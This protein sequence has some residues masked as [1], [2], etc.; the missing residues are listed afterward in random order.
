MAHTAAGRQCG[1]GPVPCSGP[2]MPGQEGRA[3]P[4]WSVGRRVTDEGEPDARI[5]EG[6]HWPVRGRVR[7]AG[8]RPHDHSA[9]PPLAERSKQNRA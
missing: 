6:S 1:A 3:I 4:G 7:H 9:P 8:V 5:G 2:W